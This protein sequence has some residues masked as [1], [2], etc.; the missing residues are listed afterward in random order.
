MLLSSSVKS[1]YGEIC[2]FSEEFEMLLDV[3]CK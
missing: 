1:G 2:I 3:R